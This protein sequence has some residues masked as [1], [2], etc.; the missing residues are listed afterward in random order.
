[1]PSYRVELRNAT[2]KDLD[3][4]NHAN[5]VNDWSQVTWKDIGRPY[6]VKTV[7][8]DKA[9]WERENGG[10]MPVKTSWEFFNRSFHEWFVKDV[11]G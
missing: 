2:S 3:K 6:E 4:F 8:K 11:V 9:E 10:T 5:V 7:A 1:M